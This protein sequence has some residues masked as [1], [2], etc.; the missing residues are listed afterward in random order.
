VAF[1][2]EALKE[3]LAAL[4]A[5]QNDGMPEEPTR[6]LV[7]LAGQ[8]ET[9]DAAS[10]DGEVALVFEQ[11]LMGLSNAIADRYFLQGSNA[12][13]TKKLGGLA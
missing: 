3:H 4:P 11:M 8:I 5:L 10:L 9:E 13:P 1:Q 6:L 12:A 2:V 7:R